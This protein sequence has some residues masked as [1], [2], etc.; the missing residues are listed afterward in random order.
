MNV[1]NRLILSE[2]EAIKIIER[3]ITNNEP[4]V[5]TYFNAHCFNIYCELKNY[6]D[7]LENFTIYPDGVGIWFLLNRLGKKYSRFNATDLNQKLIQMIIEMKKSLLIIGGNFDNA[8]VKDKCYTKGLN[9]SA[10]INGFVS[11]EEIISEVLKNE[12]EVIFI[13]MGVPKQE[14][15]ALK[16]RKLM[17]SKKIVCVGN[18][19]NYFFEFQKRAPLFM[20]KIGLE[21]LFRLFS[22]PKRL[23]I[24]YSI[25]HIKFLI[26]VI[27]FK[28]SNRN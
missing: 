3:K 5:I 1:F 24:R 8:I 20:Q 26:R 23:F 4:L 7:A 10:Y 9:F 17:P 12:A 13:G 28:K 11:D 15:L 22:E 18:F 21:W 27:K 14:F 16:I 6:K 2:T 25:G 19:F